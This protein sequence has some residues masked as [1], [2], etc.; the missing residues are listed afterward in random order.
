MANTVSD[1]PDVVFKFLG[2]GEGRT[3]EARDPLPRGVVKAFDVIGFPCFLGNGFVLGR[4]NDTSIG[5]L[6]IRVKGGLLTICRRDIGP[7]LGCTFATPIANMEGHVLARGGVH[8][9]PQPL[10]IRL[11]LDNATHFVRLNVRSLVDHRI[12]RGDGP[13]MQMVW[14]G[15]KACAHKVH[16]PP[17]AHTHHTAN[18][19]EADFLA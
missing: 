14:Q 16:K 11:L 8:R 5:F 13:Y 4:R 10:L 15:G 7:Q 17:N 6:L 2:E 9:Q 12:W 18:P 19:V 3:H 1:P